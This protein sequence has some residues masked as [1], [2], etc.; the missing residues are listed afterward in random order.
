M[1]SS[2]ALSFY[3]SKIILDRQNNIGGVQIVLDKSKFKKDSP[4][5]SNLN[6][7]KMIWTR[8]KQFAP[9]QNNLDGPK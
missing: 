3:G 1:A 7:T 5:K 8:P 4:D 6:L 2:N 9:V